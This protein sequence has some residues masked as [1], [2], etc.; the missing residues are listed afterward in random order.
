MLGGMLALSLASSWSVGCAEL[1]AESGNSAMAPG[2]LGVS[3]LD[4]DPSALSV[5]QQTAE[6]PLEGGEDALL[7]PKIRNGSDVDFDF[8]YANSLLMINVRGLPC[9][10]QVI[11]GRFL[12]TAAHCFH[13]A[14]PGFYAKPFKLNAQFTKRDGTRKTVFD[15]DAYGALMPDWVSPENR[16]DIGLIYLSTPI[17][18]CNSTIS[19]CQANRPDVPMNAQFQYYDS[20]ADR[21][22]PTHAPY[23]AAAYGGTDDFD[24]FDTSADDL[25]LRANYTLFERFRLFTDTRGGLLLQTKWTADSATAR[26]C[27]GDS[28][29]PLIPAPNF[30]G[31]PH[32]SPNRTF[33]TGVLSGS[34][35][36]RQPE[37]ISY[38]SGLDIARANWVVQNLA[39][40]GHLIGFTCSAVANLPTETFAFQCAN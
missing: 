14:E 32:P 9:T 35:D 10:A 26:M 19:W 4:L 27:N 16:F 36:C 33:Y 30:F 17:S 22:L 5:V 12:M 24:D 1:P 28:G 7:V 18:T 40:F 21:S 2:D 23:F 38:Y 3:E 34:I 13:R 29:S 8:G 15:G 6:T 20:P 39:L 11:N 25:K 31:V 37:G